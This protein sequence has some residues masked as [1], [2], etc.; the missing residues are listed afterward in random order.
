MQEP[1]NKNME[2]L[3]GAIE[4]RTGSAMEAETA[5]LSE[6]HSF[7][8]PILEESGMGINAEVSTALLSRP[9]ILF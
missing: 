4:K 2:R 3:L 6:N 7:R 5:T 9:S 1:F 8:G